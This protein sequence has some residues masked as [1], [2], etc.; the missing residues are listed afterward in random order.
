MGA[1]VGAAVALEMAEETAPETEETTEEAEAEAPDDELAPAVAVSDGL[2]VVW[3]LGVAW[4][5]KSGDICSSP[6][7]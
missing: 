5:S 2:A 1:E 7:V 6:V 3:T 4:G